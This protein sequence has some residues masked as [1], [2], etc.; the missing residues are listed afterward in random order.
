MEKKLKKSLAMPKKLKRDTVV[1]SGIVFTRETFLVQFLGHNLASSQIFVE[2]LVELFWS[3][4]VILKN[5][6]EKS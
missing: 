3:L 4:Q 1:S 5:T 6:D 2:L